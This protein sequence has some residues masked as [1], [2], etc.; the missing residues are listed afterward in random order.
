M[1]RRRALK[2][3]GSLSR[4]TRWTPILRHATMEP[5][6]ELSKKRVIM[7]NEEMGNMKYGK[8]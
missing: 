3:A 6:T 2:I 7:R 1:G 4:A 8:K 5:P